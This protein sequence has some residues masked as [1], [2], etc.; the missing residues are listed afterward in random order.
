VAST[1][2]FEPNRPHFEEL[3]FRRRPAKW[4]QKRQ[5]GLPPYLSSEHCPEGSWELACSSRGRSASPS[6]R[7][8]SS[9]YG[10]KHVP[11]PSFERRES[12]M[13]SLVPYRTP[14]VAGSLRIDV[15]TSL[16]KRI[17]SV[18]GCCNKAPTKG[19]FSKRQNE[20]QQAKGHHCCGMRYEV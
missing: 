2:N 6:G 7:I 3:E 15:E 16:E 20:I 12:Y 14:A 19:R 10:S 11:Q 17:P 4:P 13:P 5:D 1:Q 18:Q 9:S 8:D